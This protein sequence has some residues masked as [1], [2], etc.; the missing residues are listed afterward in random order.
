MPRMDYAEPD[1]KVIEVYKR[2]RSFFAWW[3]HREALVLTDRRVAVPGHCDRDASEFAGEEVYGEEEQLESRRARAQSRT[4][5]LG[6][7][8]V[9]GS[10][11][12]AAAGARHRG[13]ATLAG[14]RIW[15]RTRN[16][17]GQSP[18]RWP[19][20][21]RRI[22]S[23]HAPGTA[24]KYPATH[25][26]CAAGNGGHESLCQTRVC[27]PGREHQGP[28]RLL[29]SQA[30]GRARRDLRRDNGDRVLLRELRRRSRRLHSPGRPAVHPCDRP[31]YLRHLRVVPPAHLSHGGEGR[32]P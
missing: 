17:P 11:A 24:A 25:T 1:A 14:E 18:D 16:A 21:A 30:G 5:D 8:L 13:P 28:R 3:K 6:L 9:C 31:Q 7:D 29:D 22:S 10:G 4:I 27:Q 32:G 20:A 19:G 2:R 12:A 15:K 23:R 26:A